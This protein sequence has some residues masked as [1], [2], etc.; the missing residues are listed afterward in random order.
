MTTT[1]AFS[2]G[3]V[4]TPHYL[5]SLAGAEILAAGGNAVD[6]VVAAN[7]ARWRN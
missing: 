5:A 6:A 3:A 2:R 1:R 4:A 7:L